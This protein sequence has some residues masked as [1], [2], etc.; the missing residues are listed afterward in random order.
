MTFLCGD[1]P[2]VLVLRRAKDVKR[3]E[4]EGWNMLGY[5][6]ICYEREKTNYNGLEDFLLLLQV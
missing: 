1:A 3:R 2:N 5:I 6:I 4:E